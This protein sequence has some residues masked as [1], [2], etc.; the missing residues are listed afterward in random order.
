MLKIISWPGVYKARH[1]I[2]H[3]ALQR[4]DEHTSMLPF[5]LYTSISHRIFHAH[6]DFPL[7]PRTIPSPFTME[8]RPCKRFCYDPRSP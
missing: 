6:F 8:T 3:A 2:Q 5:A 7:L 4:G 1:T